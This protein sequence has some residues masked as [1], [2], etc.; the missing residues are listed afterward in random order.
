MIRTGFIFMRSGMPP[1]FPIRR[2]ALLNRLFS[3]NRVCTQYLSNSYP[4]CLIV[5]VSPA[6]IHYFPC[7]FF[8]AFPFVY[9]ALNDIRNLLMGVYLHQFPQPLA[10]GGNPALCS[11]PYDIDHQFP[12][13]FL[14]IHGGQLRYLR[15]EH[16]CRRAFHLL[17]NIVS[18]HHFRYCPLRLL[19]PG[20]GCGLKSRHKVI[21]L[22]L[23]R[24]CDFILHGVDGAN[25]IFRFCISFISQRIRKIFISFCKI[26]VYRPDNAVCIRQEGFCNRLI[27]I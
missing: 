18:I 27:I 22:V 16:I 24:F 20:T 11:L 17:R 9:G 23:E 6:S 15:L 25:G 19:P 14:H 5:F 2:W 1:F 13:R 8:N 3:G 7:Q 4:P 12:I 26:L 21:G 10:P